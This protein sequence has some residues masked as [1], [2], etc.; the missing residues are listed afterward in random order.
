[1]RRMFLTIAVGTLV[2]VSAN[3]QSEADAP[4]HR[5]P[6]M[7]LGEHAVAVPGSHDCSIY[8]PVLVGIKKSWI[9]QVM[10]GFDIDETGTPQSVRVLERSAFDVMDKAAVECVR[11]RWRYTPKLLNGQPVAD[12]GRK[13]IITFTTGQD[14]AEAPY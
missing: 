4:A 8:A 6:P 1:M 2:A 12:T 11:E 13:A 3:A 5:S 14:G 9:A 7:T 10:V